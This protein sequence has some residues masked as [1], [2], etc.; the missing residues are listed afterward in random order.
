MLE[1]ER[2]KNQSE[3]DNESHKL[4][5][6]SWIQHFKSPSTVRKLHAT[7]GCQMGDI[8]LVGQSRAVI[9]GRT[10]REESSLKQPPELPS[11][12]QKIRKYSIGGVTGTFSHLCCSFS[13]SWSE[14]L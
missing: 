9:N 3:N 1:F 2:T 11:C 6:N 14:S 13:L 8:N 5:E 10:G 4:A 7:L 12:S